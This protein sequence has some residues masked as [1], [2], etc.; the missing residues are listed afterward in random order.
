M[1]SA[2]ALWALLNQARDLPYGPVR[3]AL[4]ERILREVDAAG[5]D[6]LAFTARLNGTTA[7]V[8]GGE[9]A[10]SFVTFSW[11]VDDFDH[12]PRPYHRHLQ[13]HL[14][15][16]FKAMVTAL[17]Q[18]P[19]VPLTRAYAVLDDMERRCREA[20]Y[21][22]QAVYQHRFLVADHIGRDD[23]ADEWYDKW[24]S[25]PRDRLSDCAGC[26]PTD[27]AGYLSSRGRFADAVA[28]ADPVLTGRLHCVEQPQSLL[29]ALM[30][31][32]LRTG[33]TQ[34]A[35][36]AHRR[37]YQLQRA[38]LAD[39]ADIAEHVE[40]CARTGNEHRG[41][42]ILRRH[43][44]WLAKAPPP[45]AAMDFAAAGGLLLRRLTELGQGEVPLARR[46]R[47]DVAAAELATELAGRAIALSRRF[48]ERNGTDRVSRGVAERL[49]AA[50]FETA[51]PLSPTTRQGSRDGTGTPPIS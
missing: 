40:F 28:R 33:R 38:N 25:T 24:Q 29:T 5:D 8:Y 42:E 10:K 51:L 41:L 14:L 35:A 50:P 4:I 9:P 20:G 2:D 3:I 17:T 45:V 22:M 13:H 16:D 6:R 1:T 39:L 44:D 11:C 37:S 21:G 36:A 7:Y 12:H 34:D 18:F 19:E 49:A 47:G 31:P 48:D 23:E 43:L 32:Y 30:V 27:V 26:D 46:G 15:W